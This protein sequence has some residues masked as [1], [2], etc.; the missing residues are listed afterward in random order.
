MAP[1]DVVYAITLTDT[2]NLS[3]RITPLEPFGDANMSA[4]LRTICDD[5]STA[6]STCAYSTGNWA[7]LTAGTYYFVMAP[8]PID[9]GGRYRL[10]FTA[11][12]P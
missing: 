1:A 4:Q 11:T 6:L 10:S 7:G 12:A 9:G 3:V 8:R 5:A 2:R